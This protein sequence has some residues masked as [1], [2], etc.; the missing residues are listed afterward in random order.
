MRCLRKYGKSPEDIEDIYW[1]LAASGAS[2]HVA[3]SVIGNPQL[4]SE[5]LQM[6]RDDVS[7]LE[8]AVRLQKS[9]GL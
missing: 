8:I 9:M 5:Y 3:K 4:L 7:D 1:V 6:K 2:E